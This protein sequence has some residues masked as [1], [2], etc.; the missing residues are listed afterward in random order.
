VIRCALEFW[1]LSGH[2]GQGQAAPIGLDQ[3]ALC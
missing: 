1:S 3:S 2:G